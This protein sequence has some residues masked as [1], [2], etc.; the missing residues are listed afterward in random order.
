MSKVLSSEALWKEGG[1]YYT[2]KPEDLVRRPLLPDAGRLRDRRILDLFRRYGNLGPESKV[3]EIGCGRSMWLPFLARTFGCQVAGL[4]I[5]AYAAELARANLKGAGVDGEI[6]CGDAFNPDAHPGLHAKFDLIY[7]MGVME[8]FDD[9]SERLAILGRYLKPGGRILTSVPNLQCVNWL[10]QR[11]ASLERLNMHVVYD[12]RRLR[13]I[14]RRAGFTSVATGYAG[15]YDGFLSGD[16]PKTPPF[17]RKLHDRLCRLSNMAGAAWIKLWRGKC[18]PETAWLS[19]HVFYVGSWN[20]ESVQ[21][22][23]AVPQRPEQPRAQALLP[24]RSPEAPGVLPVADVQ[25]KPRVALVAASLE[26]LG[27]QGVQ[28]RSLIEGLQQ[29]NYPVRFIPINPVF[30]RRLRRWRGVRYLRTLLNQA[31][32]LPS[33]AALRNVD[34]VHVFSAAY[35]SFLLAPVP[36]MLAARLFGKRVVLHYHSGE[37]YDHLANW[38]VFV[39]PW[40]RLADE[41]VVPSEYLRE[42]FSRHG[43]RPRV[44]RNVVDTTRF[45]F[46]PRN[47]L[48]PHL[49]SVRNFESYYRVDIILQAFAYIRHSFPDATLTLAGV[50]S[51]EPMLRQLAARQPGGGIRFVGRVEPRQ[52]QE[53]YDGADIFV[54]AS[55]VDNQPVSVLEAFAAGLPVV[56]TA[57]GDIAAMV[58]DGETGRIVPP[59]DP[60]AI[61][62]AVT[63]LL[64]DP[65]SAQ[66]LAQQARVE[67]E[68]YTWFKV[69]DAWALA[70]KGPQ[71]NG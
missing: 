57:T 21:R 51:E 50:G 47:P 24:A 44:I 45:S 56:T 28:A 3:L 42:V 58:R 30:P 63:G 54:N 26:I 32:Y 11:L 12:A 65:D 31:L 19:P 33:L 53:L 64:G 16:D 29:E 14:H 67:A 34:V 18:T 39:H 17:R 46:R 2:D 22:T 60:L 9:A 59:E 40:L 27:G 61:A 55:V 48:R 41:I 38:G 8:H 7:S 62:Q 6:V 52:M 70:Y 69:R 15:F 4:D 66:L 37:A 5:E 25:T 1:G 43:Y 10:M 13:E 68:S 36:A 35:W 49:L 71:S 20:A 23:A